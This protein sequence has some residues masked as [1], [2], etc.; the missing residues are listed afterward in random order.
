MTSIVC[1]AR[2]KAREKE[3]KEERCFKRALQVDRN[4]IVVF[5]EQWVED[6]LG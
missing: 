1:N 2:E 6:M 4:G 5:I 3:K